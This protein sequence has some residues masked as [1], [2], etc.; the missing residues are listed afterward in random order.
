MPAGGPSICNYTAAVPLVEL[1]LL[2][3]LGL[4]AG[5]IGGLVGVGGSIVIIPI[6]TLLM[7][8]DQH[9]SQAAAMIV[10]VFVAASALLRHHQALAVRWDVVARMLPFG[11]LFIIIGVEASNQIDGE[12]LK[13]IYGGFLLYVI[14]FNV[15]KLFQDGGQ[16]ADAA[17][18]RIGWG[19]VGFIGGLMG[20][21]AGLLGI[22]G[23]PIAMPLLQRVCNLP[24]RQAIA[25]SSAVMCLTSIVGAVRK[26]ATLAEH[27]DA[28]GHA[29]GLQDSL[30]IAAALAPTAMVGALI[31]AGL[32]HTLPLRWVRVAFILLMTWASASMLGLV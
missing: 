6:L 2:L 22:G 10:N 30:L 26:N 21:V 11:L 8:R 7:S 20:L 5:A 9:L 31:G 19:P 16:S 12:I 24:L 1:I 28:A 3:V 4:F 17:R 14:V 27:M 23:G 18:P 13:K 29:L 32:T 15:T 25:A